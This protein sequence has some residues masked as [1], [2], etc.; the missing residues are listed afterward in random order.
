MAGSVILHAGYDVRLFGAD[1]PV[2]EIPGADHPH[3]PA[4]FGFTTPPS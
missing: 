2:D 1:L 3:R 4:V